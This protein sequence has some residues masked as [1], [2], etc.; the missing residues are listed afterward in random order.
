M[1][2]TSRVRLRYDLLTY[3]EEE[4]AEKVRDL[5]DDEVRAIGKRAFD[6]TF[7]TTKGHLDLALT[8]AAVETMEGGPRPLRRTTPMKHEE[9]ATKSA[10]ETRTCTR[11]SGEHQST[12][13]PQSPPRTVRS[14]GNDGNAAGPRPTRPHRRGR[15][16][17]GHSLSTLEGNELIRMRSPGQDR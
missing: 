12:A 5:T 4:L 11:L 8:L 6:L 14:D 10:M 13:T 16:R 7:S 1:I 2:N 15:S 3:G 9:I 17:G